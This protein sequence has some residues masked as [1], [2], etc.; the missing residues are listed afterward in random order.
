[1]CLSSCTSYNSLL[2]SCLNG[3]VRR[4]LFFFNILE[5]GCREGRTVAL[6]TERWL[7]ECLSAKQEQNMLHV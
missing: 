2:L 1:M 6:L 7:P 3:A 4:S 5:Q